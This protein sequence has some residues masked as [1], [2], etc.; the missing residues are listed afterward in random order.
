[1]GFLPGDNVRLKSTGKTVTVQQSN[2]HA[3]KAGAGYLKAASV[4]RYF[5]F[6]SV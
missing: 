5:N 4:K 3:V 2:G 6:G 1:M